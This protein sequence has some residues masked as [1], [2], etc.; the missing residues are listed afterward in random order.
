MWL[1][2]FKFSDDHPYILRMFMFVLNN[3]FTKTW[4]GV[5][6]HQVHLL[7]IKIT[8]NKKIYFSSVTQNQ[9]LGIFD[10]KNKNHCIEYTFLFL[11]L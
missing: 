4:F 10:D 3:L 6:V 1:D 9:R 8:I 7:I 5:N 2:D 11:D